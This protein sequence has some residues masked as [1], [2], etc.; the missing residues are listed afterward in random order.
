[1]YSRRLVPG[2]WL[3]LVP[4]P[5]RNL[6]PLSR[7]CLPPGRQLALAWFYGLAGLLLQVP[8]VLADGDY[9]TP[10]YSLTSGGAQAIASGDYVLSGAVGQVEATAVLESGE[11]VLRPGFWVLSDPEATGLPGLGAAVP[12]HF[13]LARPF[14]NPSS[15]SIVLAIDVPA[16]QILSV[17]IFSVDGRR[18]RSLADRS[19]DPGQVLLRWDGR[20]DEGRK[21]AGG[22]FFA[23]AR[24]GT[25]EETTRI[26]RIVP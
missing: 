12:L 4:R 24:L 3:R 2:R 21:T 8:P 16:A 14:P 9:S 13:R 19:V 15:D 25:E 7:R 22:V 5:H 6:Q 17:G 11:Y 23:R 10:W 20:D 1:M 26:V 18:V